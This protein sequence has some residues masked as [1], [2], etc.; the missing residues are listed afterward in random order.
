M[1]NNSITK[2]I[3]GSLKKSI[4]LDSN[5]KNKNFYHNNNEKYNNQS[6]N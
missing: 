2:S 6:N 1:N 3:Q 4:P 5:N